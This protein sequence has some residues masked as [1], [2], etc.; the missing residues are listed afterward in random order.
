[1]PR[2]GFVDM[3]QEF[4][5]GPHVALLGLASRDCCISCCGARLVGLGMETPQDA[6]QLVQLSLCRLECLKLCGHDIR[7]LGPASIDSRAT[8]NFCCIAAKEKVA[9]E[10]VRQSYVTQ[11]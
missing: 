4:E 8:R 10:D 9:R 2:C 3:S 6:M 5:G 7:V 1:M 11:C